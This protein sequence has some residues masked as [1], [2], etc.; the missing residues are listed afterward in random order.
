VKGAQV[1]IRRMIRTR[2]RNMNPQFPLELE[3]RRSVPRDLMQP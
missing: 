3:R 2:R 1:E